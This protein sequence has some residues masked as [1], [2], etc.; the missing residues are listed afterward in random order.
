MMS[1]QI[2]LSIKVV[3]GT[4]YLM[5]SLFMAVGWELPIHYQPR[6]GRSDAWAMK[7]LHKKIEID[8]GNKCSC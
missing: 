5:D 2:S 8:P 6:C 1:A 3:N 4:T 7:Q